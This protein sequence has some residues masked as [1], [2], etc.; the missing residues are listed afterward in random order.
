M[1][2]FEFVQGCKSCLRS[3]G[4]EKQLGVESENVYRDLYTNE[5]PKSEYGVSKVIREIALKQGY[6]CIFC[7][8]TN[9]DILDLTYKGKKMPLDE[10]T[11]QFQI[12]VSR[13][14]NG[15]ISVDF[16]GS[17]YLPK[18]FAS[19]AIDMIISELNSLDEND[20]EPLSI[21]DAFFNV[22]SETYYIRRRKEYRHAERIEN[23]R[24]YG[25]KRHEIIDAINNAAKVLKESNPNYFS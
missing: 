7:S 16:G 19:T 23:F 17:Q 4:L 8:S 2:N 10:Y 24:F 15:D 20:F 22:S 13:L 11:S 6:R 5:I 18:S 9:I 21:S 1:V 3:D 25:F 14:E 12:S